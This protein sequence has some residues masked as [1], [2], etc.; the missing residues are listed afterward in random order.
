MPKGSASEETVGETKEAKER[1]VQEWL[2]KYHETFPEL[3]ASQ[4]GRF[5]ARCTVCKCDF[6]VSHGGLTVHIIIAA[7]FALLR[8]EYTF[9][10]GVFR[11]GV[12]ALRILEDILKILEN[13]FFFKSL[14][15]KFGV[16]SSESP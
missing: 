2:P 9:W 14:R 6:T 7:C 11:A 8:P 10:R 4:K 3:I 1:R 5:Y 12:I 13:F 16:G 15:P